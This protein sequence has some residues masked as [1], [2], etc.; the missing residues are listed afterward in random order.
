M[1]ETE[2][3]LIAEAVARRVLEVLPQA[4][5]QQVFT[6]A[7]AAAYLQMD[8]DQVATL[9]R[10]GRLMHWRN[11]REYR[12]RRAALDAWMADEETATER[13]RVAGMRRTA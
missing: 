13:A 12:F 4:D 9:A 3:E 5:Q 1:T 11:G 8:E 7:E 10:A 2:V 6:L